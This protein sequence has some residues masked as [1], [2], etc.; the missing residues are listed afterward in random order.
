MHLFTR[1]SLRELLLVVFVV[2]LGFAGLR[3]GGIVAQLYFL[4]ALLV[5]MSA[6]IGA[7][8][9]VGDT[10]TRSRGFIVDMVRVL[11][12]PKANSVR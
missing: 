7:C 1:S 8:V 12:F 3:L 9:T 4:L 2:G 6:A 5:V 11:L 10:R